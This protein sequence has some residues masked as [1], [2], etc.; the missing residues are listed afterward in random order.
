GYTAGGHSAP[1]RGRLTLDDE[2]Q[3]VY[4]PKDVADLAAIARLGLPF[5][6]AGGA[7]SPERVA[8]ALEVG[9]AGVQSGTL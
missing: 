1:P 8:E 7:G 9:A 6:L 4:G 2:G 5:W 3:P